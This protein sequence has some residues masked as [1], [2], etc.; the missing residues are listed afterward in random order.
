VARNDQD[1]LNWEQMNVNRRF[2]L[3]LVAVAGSF[4][5]A[6]QGGE[7]HN[8]IDKLEI[9]KVR[10]L[11]KTQP[12]LVNGRDQAGSTPLHHAVMFPSTN[13]VELLLASGAKVN[14]KDTLGKTPL[15][16]A[17]SSGQQEI[18]KLLLDN[19]ADVNAQNFPSDRI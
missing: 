14:E 15:L 5:L 13:I 16:W 4:L 1:E 7:I 10:T 18:A 12:E 17:C 11:L 3:I 19:K 6:A 2:V 8:A 9:D